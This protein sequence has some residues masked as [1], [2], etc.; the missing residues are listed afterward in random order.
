MSLKN[1]YWLSWYHR[2]EY[3]EFELHWPWW[4]SGTTIGVDFEETGSTIC[5]AIRATGVA[6]A[7][8]VIEKSYDNEQRNLEWRFANEQR[9]DWSPF[10][11]RFPK[12]DWMT[13]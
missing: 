1:N 2:P 5:T 7:K 11:D 3:G 12:A 6:E 9:R 13:W 8:R 10:G 4:V